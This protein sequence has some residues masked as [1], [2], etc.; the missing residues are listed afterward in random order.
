MPGQ[1]GDSIDN[2]GINYCSP[3][4]C[5]RWALLK[6]HGSVVCR[7]QGAGPCPVNETELCSGEAHSSSVRLWDPA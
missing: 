6:K 2:S 1:S 5:L 7:S 4:P 3:F